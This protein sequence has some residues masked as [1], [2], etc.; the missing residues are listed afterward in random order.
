MMVRLFVL[1]PSLA[2]TPPL[3]IIAVNDAGDAE[4]RERV[5]LLILFLN[6]AISLWCR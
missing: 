2:F 1:F 6:S 4:K 5:D 3:A